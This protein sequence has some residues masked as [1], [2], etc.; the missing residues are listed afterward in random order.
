M[1][2]N[3]SVWVRGTWAPLTEDLKNIRWRLISR[4]KSRLES[5]AI[6]LTWWGKGA[7]GTIRRFLSREGRPGS[8]FCFNAA[9]CWP[10]VCS[11]L[12]PAKH[13][14]LTVISLVSDPEFKGNCEGFCV[15]KESIGLNK[16]LYLSTPRLPLPAISYRNFRG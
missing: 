14:P 1:S 10:I 6:S 16:Q 7:W 15:L 13:W 11:Q 4:R 3:V 9:Q 12:R 8:C 2:S 5:R